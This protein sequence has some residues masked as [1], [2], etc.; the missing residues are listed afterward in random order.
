M[1]VGGRLTYLHGDHPG[2]T[3][4]E[5]VRGNATTYQRHCTFGQTGYNLYCPGGYQVFK[6]LE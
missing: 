2:A 1:C 4:L 3:V 5:R 6:V